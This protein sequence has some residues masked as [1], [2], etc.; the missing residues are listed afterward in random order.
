M[1]LI[2]RKKVW[3]KKVILKDVWDYFGSNGM[4]IL[5]KIMWLKSFFWSIIVINLILEKKFESNF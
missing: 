1:K 3:G 2:V 4:S 5:G